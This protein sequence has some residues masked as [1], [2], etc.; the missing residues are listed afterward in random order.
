MCV[1]VRV[2]V[3]V[4]NESQDPQKP[5]GDLDLGHELLRDL[6]WTQAERLELRQVQRADAKNWNGSGYIIATFPA[7][8]SSQMVLKSTG[9]LPKMAGPG[10]IIN[11]PD[12]SNT[13]HFWRGKFSRQGNLETK[14]R[15]SGKVF[16]KS[17]LEKFRRLR[18]VNVTLNLK[19]LSSQPSSCLTKMVRIPMSS[20]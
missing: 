11:C 2:R 19:T 15:Q 4:S 14:I 7:G 13:A 6:R 12:G 17:V 9:I 20:R 5:A 1:C 16:R 3:R 10:F 18:F 8:W